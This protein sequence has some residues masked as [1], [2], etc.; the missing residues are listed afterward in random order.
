MLS[1]VFTLGHKPVKS[2]IPPMNDG[3]VY[4][5]YENCGCGKKLNIYNINE[6]NGIPVCNAYLFKMKV[7]SDAVIA[8]H[9]MQKAIDAHLKREL[10]LKEAAQRVKEAMRSI[11]INK[12]VGKSRR[13]KRQRWRRKNAYANTI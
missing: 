3:N 10:K 11:V 6:I 9:L 2:L 8:G 7:K 5:E 1:Y 4:C 12:Q 13:P